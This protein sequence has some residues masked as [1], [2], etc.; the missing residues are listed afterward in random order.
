MTSM[1]YSEAQQRHPKRFED[2]EAKKL[3]GWQSSVMRRGSVMAH[4]QNDESSWHD[5]YHT[6]YWAY[7][8]T[9]DKD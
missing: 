5:K 4:L 7:I 9:R 6:Q 1:W 2:E 3:K 8:N